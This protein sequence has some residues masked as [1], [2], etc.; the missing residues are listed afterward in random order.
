MVFF[1]FDTVHFLNFEKNFPAFATIFEILRL[2]IDTQTVHWALFCQFFYNFDNMNSHKIFC[3]F[4]MLIP[5]FGFFI[6]W[7]YYINKSSL[8]R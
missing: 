2:K 8:S 3:Y 4:W 6:K 7:N 1:G 5:N